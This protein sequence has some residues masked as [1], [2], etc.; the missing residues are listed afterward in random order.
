[1]AK[2]T[3]SGKKSKQSTKSR[4]NN[5]RVKTGS[6]VAKLVQSKVEHLIHGQFKSGLSKSTQK[7]IVSYGPWAATLLVII[8]LPELMVLAKDSALMGFNGFFSL[9]FFNQQSWVIMLV[10]LANILLLVDGLG[11]LFEKRSRG[12]QRIYQASLI[13]TAYIAYQLFTNTLAAILSLIV[14]FAIL[15]VIL[16]IKKYYK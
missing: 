13:S 7:K 1:M 14:M 12:W 4:A 9:I 11:Y 6:E 10:L 15:F 8:V 16:D 2:S 3:K 5:V